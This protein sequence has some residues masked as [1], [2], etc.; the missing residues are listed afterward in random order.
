MTPSTARTSD[1]LAQMANGERADAVQL[2][3][4]LDQFS[5]RAFGVLLLF[6]IAPALLPV[7]VGVGAISGPFVA[8]LGL[9]LLLVFE[10]PWLPRMLRRRGIARA[11][12]RSMTARLQPL[13][14]RFERISRPRLE[15][16][17]THPAGSMFTG[18]LLILLGVLISLPI[19]LTNYPFGLLI[20]GYA[21]A[22][23]ERD[24]ALLLAVWTIGVAACIASA[25]LSREVMDL[26]TRAF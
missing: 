14:Q 19:P 13:L 8:L 3:E 23:I 18:L 4:L 22:L 12:F 1:L 5:Q 6:A 11:R 9:Q 24:G 16:L 25:I 2:D 15:R 7:P 21:L 10:H 26:L 20:L 17:I